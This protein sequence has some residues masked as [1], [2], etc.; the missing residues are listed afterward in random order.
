MKLTVGKYLNERI[1]KPS[2]TAPTANL[3]LPG[4]SID[5]ETVV[6]GDEVDGNGIWYK[7]IEGYYYWSGGFVEIDFSLP[8]CIIE[9][10]S[11]E[12]QVKI[13]K[14]FQAAADAV[15]KQA[16]LGYLGCGFGN[17]NYIPNSDLSLIV[18][19]DKK[20]QEND[21]SL[22]YRVAKEI[23]FW[24]LAIKTDVIAL[25]TA[26]HHY[27]D[28]R[29]NK[30]DESDIPIKI[31]G[32]IKDAGKKN[33]GT[34]SLGV[35]RKDASE[36][37]TYY[38]I[39]SYHVVLDKLISNNETNYKGT[40]S[41]NSFF[42]LDADLNNNVHEIIEGNYDSDYDYVAIKLN[43]EFDIL[44]RIN[45]LEISGFFNYDELYALKDKNVTTIGFSSGIQ[46]GK[47]LSIFN[48]ITLK[49]HFQEFKNVIFAEKISTAGDSGAPVIE[50]ESGKLIGFVI[51]GNDIDTSFI[52][53]YYNLSYEKKFEIPK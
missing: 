12:D 16:V 1:G 43:S 38:L 27:D 26:Y 11:S 50:P 19:V 18:Y 7:A 51:G 10:F 2:V 9:S 28:N 36:Q 48:K 6:Y 21:P 31:G 4:D 34:R 17:K 32:G 14:Q 52:L 22:K 29:N 30:I 25:D 35:W 44:N 40:P 47:V 46:S 8:G 23:L 13:L 15:F 49:P 33:I 41:F 5:I 3:K 37:I 45:G 24:G 39:A 42:P 53:P 20:V